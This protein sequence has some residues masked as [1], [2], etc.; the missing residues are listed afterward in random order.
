MN[1]AQPAPQKAFAS[2]ADLEEKKV[3]F[4]QPVP[5]THLTL[6]TILRVYYSEAPCEPTRHNTY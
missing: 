3:R 1:T 5:S 4:T 6:P 2:Q